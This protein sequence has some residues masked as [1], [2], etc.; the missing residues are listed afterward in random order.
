MLPLLQH[1]IKEYMTANQ[2]AYLAG[3]EK[4]CNPAATAQRIL[5]GIQYG[6]TYGMGPNPYKFDVSHDA[7]RGDPETEDGNAVDYYAFGCD[8]FRPCID[9]SRTQVLGRDNLQQAVDQLAAGE[10][11]VFL[12]NHQ[13]EADPQVVSCCLELAGERQAAE[14]M[15][16]VAGHKV[17]T[18]PL[19]IPFSMGRNL[20]CIH[21]KKTH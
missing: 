9:L 2:K 8:F 6:L 11:V 3:N 1:F 20:I 14:D 13:S 4:D 5:T 21:S 7:L 18:D 17:T 10:N 16:Y 19:A 15:V 12:A